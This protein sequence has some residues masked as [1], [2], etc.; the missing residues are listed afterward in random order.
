MELPDDVIAIIKGYSQ[1]MTR[2]DWRE[3]HLMTSRLYHSSVSKSRKCPVFKIARRNN[4]YNY[5][6][7]I[8]G[9]SYEFYYM[10][11]FFKP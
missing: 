1:P 7:I 6:V 3:L 8:H 9:D 10:N 2:P 5:S 4:R 11:D